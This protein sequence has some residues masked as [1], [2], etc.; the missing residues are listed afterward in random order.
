M[1]CQ[2]NINVA[3]GPD[4][5]LQVCSTWFDRFDEPRGKMAAPENASERQACP[6]PL[7]GLLFRLRDGF[8]QTWLCGLMVVSCQPKVPRGI[9]GQEVF[10]R[11]SPWRI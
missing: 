7:L 5:A 10:C 2:P 6:T 8:A 1:G 3:V 11:G 9:L 4:A